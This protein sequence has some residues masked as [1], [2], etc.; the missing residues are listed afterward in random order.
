MLNS[1]EATPLLCDS[2][3]SILDIVVETIKWGEEDYKLFC[4]LMLLI[5]APLLDPVYR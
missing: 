5:V 2:R 1:V 3:L 4:L